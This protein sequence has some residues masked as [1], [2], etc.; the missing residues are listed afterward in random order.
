MKE[1]IDKID[2]VDGI[3]ADLEETCEVP[4]DSDG[5]IQVDALVAFMEGVNWL[6]AS[7]DAIMAVID[8]HVNEEGK[9]DY[10]VALHAIVQD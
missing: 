3:I 4:E 9:I 2:P 8:R 6:D 1:Q 10:K 7:K 5:L